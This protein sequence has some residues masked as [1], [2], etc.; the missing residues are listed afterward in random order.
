MEYKITLEVV[1][2][3]ELG[4]IEKLFITYY[5]GKLDGLREY[6]GRP[7]QAAEAE[8]REG[9]LKHKDSL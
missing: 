5:G 7:K 4:G 6:Y 8:I 3:P 2:H 1:K 9:Y